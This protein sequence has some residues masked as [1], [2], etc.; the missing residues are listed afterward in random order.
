MTAPPYITRKTRYVDTMDDFPTAPWVTRAFVELVMCGGER[1]RIAALGNRTMHEPAC[2]R[3][4]MSRTLQEYCDKVL[5]SDIVDYGWQHSVLNYL[6]KPCPAT[7]FKVTN[8]PFALAEQFWHKMYTE[9]RLGVG[10]FAKT[11]WMENPGRYE[12][13]FSPVPPNVVAVLSKRMPGAKNM[14]VRKASPYLSHAWFWWD[15]RR[16]ATETRLMWLPPNTQQQ[17]ERD[18]D[19]G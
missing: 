13:I 2:G 19:Y 18:E 16:P 9:S 15:K 6:E 11:L 12:R 17:F 1:R 14:V 10:L 7:D 4:H 8:A 5:R 3:G